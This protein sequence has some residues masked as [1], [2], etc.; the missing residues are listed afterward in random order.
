MATKAELKVWRELLGDKINSFTD[1]NKIYTVWFG[2]TGF[3]CS[4]PDFEYR[5]GSYEISFNDTDGRHRVQ[6]CKHIAKHLHRCGMKDLILA[7]DGF[8]YTFKEIYAE[9]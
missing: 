2:E 6:G 5:D 8:L 7:K 1:E 9:D 3:E 4:C